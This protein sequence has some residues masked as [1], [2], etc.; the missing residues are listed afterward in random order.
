MHRHEDC[1]NSLI[2]HRLKVPSGRELG[3]H[4]EEACDSDELRIS[5]CLETLSWKKE[6]WLFPG[7]EPT[8]SK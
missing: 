6:D 1:S 3:K 7:S 4:T 8:L 5:L 2:E